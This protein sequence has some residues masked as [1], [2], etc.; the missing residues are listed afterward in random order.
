MRNI[1]SGR[2]NETTTHSITTTCFFI[3]VSGLDQ[4]RSIFFVFFHLTLIPA[5]RRDNHV[6]VVCC[7]CTAAAPSLQ[8]I[9]STLTGPCCSRRMG[10]VTTNGRRG[11]KVVLCH[12][13][14][15][16]TL[17]DQTHSDLIK[18]FTIQMCFEA[19]LKEL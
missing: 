14:N 12:S 13:I 19:L 9:S 4:F 5:R 16:W 7:S 6:M 10:G 8:L 15:Y 11:L 3:L 18:K 1:S 2:D 17:P